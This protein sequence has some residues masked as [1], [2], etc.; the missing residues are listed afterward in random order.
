MAAAKKQEL[1]V[2]VLN[3]GMGP[4]DCSAVL[5]GLKESSKKIGSHK[6]RELYWNVSKGASGFS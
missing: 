1:L 6:A 5:E 4:G 2:L 3:A